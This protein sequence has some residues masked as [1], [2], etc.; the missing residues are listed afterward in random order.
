M[1]MRWA[2]INERSKFVTFTYFGG[3]FG[4]LVTYPLCGFL[5][6]K[7]DWEVSYLCVYL[8]KRIKSIDN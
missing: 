1:I 5:L 4:V 7:Y 2:P 8:E 6:Q 3:T